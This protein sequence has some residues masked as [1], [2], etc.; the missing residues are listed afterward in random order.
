MRFAI[1]GYCLPDNFADNVSFTLR[2]MGHDVIVPSVPARFLD[3]RIRHLAEV[4]IERVFPNRITPQERWL[5]K[6][7]REYKPDVMIALTQGI[8]EEVLMDLRSR[9]VQ[10]IAWWGDTAANMRK[11]GLLAYGWDHIFIKDRFAVSKLKTLDLPAHFLPEAMNPAWHKPL[12]R[13]IGKD[14]VFAGNTY[15]Y[16]HF[17]IRQMLK[18]GVENIKLYG[19]FPSRWADPSVKA[20]FTGRHIVKE[21]KSRVFGEALACINSTAM[22]EGNSVN[23]RAFEVAG[24]GG[25]QIMEYRQA[26]EDCFDPGKEILTYACIEELREKIAFYQ[27][28]Q[29]ASISIREAASKRALSQ[30]TYRHR[31]EEIIRIIQA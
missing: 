7:V 13:S 22:S 1:P 21:E 30:H 19:S 16:R 17:L 29:H 27:L 23:C 26:I 28:N 15:D 2:S 11:Q 3:Y 12:Y 25:L 20:L 31:L 14:V 6:V 10:N 9:G 5:L 4:G 24:A 18:A 8:S